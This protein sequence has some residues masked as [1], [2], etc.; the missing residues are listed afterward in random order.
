MQL[1]R[2]G[3]T[4]LIDSDSS[5]LGIVYVRPNWSIFFYIMC[6][7]LSVT[8]RSRSPLGARS[9]PQKNKQTA[10]SST[11][12]RERKEKEEEEVE[13]ERGGEE[14][15]KKERGRDRNVKATNNSR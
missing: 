6:A 13:R 9:K 2:N 10:R 14:A 12:S 11:K 8:S 3:L 1:G 5:N 4:Y 15:R 7:I